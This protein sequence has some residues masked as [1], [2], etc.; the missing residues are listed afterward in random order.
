MEESTF[1]ALKASALERLGAQLCQLERVVWY[2]IFINHSTHGGSSLLFSRADFFIH[3]A[4]TTEGP[5]GHADERFWIKGR[6]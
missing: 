6:K 5:R 3:E 1:F 2:A 4:S